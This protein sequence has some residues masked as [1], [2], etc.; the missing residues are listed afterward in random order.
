MLYIILFIF[1]CYSFK[2]KDN[3]SALGPH[4]CCS[5]K[6]G[7]VLPHSLR[8]EACFPIEISKSD[9]IY[10]HCNMSCMEFVRSLTS[11]PTDC[12]L[13]PAQPVSLFCCFKDFSVDKMNQNEDR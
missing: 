6:G 11:V 1:H 2:Y 5:D 4:K 10:K 8:A 9:P 3:I 12:V 7:Q 13:G